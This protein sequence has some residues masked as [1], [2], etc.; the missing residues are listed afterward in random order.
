MPMAML[1]QRCH[2]QTALE[3]HHL[4]WDTEPQ[5]ELERTSVSQTILRKAI[6][7]LLVLVVIP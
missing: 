7:V 2:A 5:G 1:R 4:T 6:R 3:P